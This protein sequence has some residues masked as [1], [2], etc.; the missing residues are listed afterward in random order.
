MAKKQASKR[1]ING[2]CTASKKLPQYCLEVVGDDEKQAAKIARAIKKGIGQ[3]ADICKLNPPVCT[4][5]LGLTRDLMPQI[6]GDANV[7][8]LVQSDDKEEVAKG[9]AILQAGGKKRDH[10]TVQQQ[11]LDYLED[12]G[13][14]TRRKRVPVGTLKATQSEIK[15]AKAY[16]MANAHLAGNFPT[17]DKQIV[18]SKDGH[19]LDGHHRWAALLT[20][21]PGRWM[22]VLEIG[23]PM[24]NAKEGRPTL[25]GEAAAFPGVY[26][27]NF[28]GD[29]LSETAQKRYK[30]ENKSL[31]HRT[32][33][34]ASRAADKKPLTE[35]EKRAKKAK[36][37]KEAQAAINRLL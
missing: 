19:I 18:I 4:E 27:A 1:N 8:E 5:N 35:A 30:A 32:K 25:L 23:L 6:T 17:I 20:I 2:E 14:R 9:R 15:A 31:L 7:L 34:G 28:A 36:A 24:A 26:K 10:R 12:K 37:R 21:D 13:I 22:N 3:A 33:R 11:F 16:G 29:P